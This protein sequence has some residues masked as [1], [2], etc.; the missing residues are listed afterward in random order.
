MRFFLIIIPLIMIQSQAFA[1]LLT[2]KHSFHHTETTTLSPESIWK[3]WTDVPTWQEWDSGLQSATIKGNW[4]LGAKGKLI[5]D[6]GPKVKFEV[7]EFVEGQSYTLRMPLP[8]GSFY[9]HRFLHTEGGQ[10]QFTHQIYFKG[11]TAGIFAKSM[12][13]RYQK[14]LPPVMQALMETRERG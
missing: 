9:L 13:E 1:Q 10:T 6:K 14:M 7:I 5:P 12:G 3:A 2:T 8:L 11:L 4:Q